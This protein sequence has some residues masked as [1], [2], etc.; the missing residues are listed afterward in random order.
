MNTYN[1]LLTVTGIVDG[2][3]YTLLDEL[4]KLSKLTNRQIAALTG[5]SPYNSDSRSIKSKLR[6]KGGRAPIR[7]VLYMAILSA[8]QCN[9]IMKE[10]NTRLVAEG[11]HKKITLTT[12]MRKIMTILNAMMRDGKEWQRLK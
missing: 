12:C 4:P 5:L 11:K 8:I 6:I 3:A 1:L 7:T 10:F 2:V 9:P